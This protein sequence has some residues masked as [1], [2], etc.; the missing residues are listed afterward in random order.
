LPPEFPIHAI[1]I[2]SL[3]EGQGTSLPRGFG[4]RNLDHE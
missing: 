4:I 1:R 2:C 3:K